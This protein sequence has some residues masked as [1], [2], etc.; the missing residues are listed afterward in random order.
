MGLFGIA[1]ILG[2]PEHFTIFFTRPIAATAM[3]TMA[4]LI[5]VQ[6]VAQWRRGR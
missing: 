1:E 6:I 2:N 5:V 4:A 3:A